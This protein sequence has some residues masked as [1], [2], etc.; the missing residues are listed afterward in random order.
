MLDPEVRGGFSEEVTSERKPV[1]RDPAAQKWGG[2]GAEVQQVQSMGGVPGAPG[3]E[4]EQASWSNVKVAH[5][6]GEGQRGDRS[7]ACPCGARILL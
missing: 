1:R 2:G 6:V 5:I 4:G 7:S 3:R